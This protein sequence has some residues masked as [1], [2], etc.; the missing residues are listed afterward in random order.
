MKDGAVQAGEPDPPSLAALPNSEPRL[1]RCERTAGLSW[2][3]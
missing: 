1:L 3:A 2:E